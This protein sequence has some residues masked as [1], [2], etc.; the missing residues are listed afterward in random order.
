M[1]KHTTKITIIILLMFLITQF[2]GL[3]II[4]YYNQPDN[5]LP[6]GMEVQET[7]DYNTVIDIISLVVAFAIAIGLF[8]LLRK[9]RAKHVIRLWFF[10]VVLISLGIF[11]TALFNFPLGLAYI[12]L[13]IAIP[14]AFFKIFRRN[15]IVHNLS[16][17]M[18]YPAIAAVFVPFLNVNG[19]IILLTIISIYD[20]WA[21][22][23]SGIM[24]KMAKFQMEEVKVF[25]GFSIPYITK[26]QRAQLKK[27]RKQKTKSKQ[28]GIK[29]RIGALGGGDSVFPLITTG[30]VLVHLGLGP[31]IFTIFGAFLGLT[32]LLLF[33]DKDK[34]YPAMPY[35]SYGALIFLGISQLIF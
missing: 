31:A 28:K 30:I 18:I 26:K 19:A 7:E 10:I 2:L 11:F 23:K 29:V 5:A 35:I 1:A 6:F 21:V 16:E 22:W 24:Q 15:L 14:I 20:M 25:G 9:K 4:N 3:W 13:L 12:G 34:F 33:S 32:L 27:L 17:L 8:F